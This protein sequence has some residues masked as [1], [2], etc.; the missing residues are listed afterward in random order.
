MSVTKDIAKSSS[1]CIVKGT[2]NNIVQRV[3][4]F[5]SQPVD[6][7]FCFRAAQLQLVTD[8]CDQGSAPPGKEN[9][10]GSSWF[11]VCILQG[12]DATSARTKDGEELRWRSHN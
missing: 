10:S 6:R 11:E 9:Q 7:D 1:S 5:K 3:V 2:E 4:W 8:S 12:P